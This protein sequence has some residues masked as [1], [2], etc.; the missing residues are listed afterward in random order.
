MSFDA[1]QVSAVLKGNFQPA[2]FFE[3]DAAMKRSAAGM[4]A[5]ETQIAG[6]SKRSA[7]ALGALGTVAK[8]GAAAGLVAVAAGLTASAK[9]A[10]DFEKSMR[11]VN[12]IAKVS[13]GQLKTMG[14]S[15]L[16]LAGKTAQAPKTL[17]DGLY[18]IV[19]SGFKGKDA[20]TILEKSA[21]A[22]SAG[23]TDTATASKAVVAVLN[24]Y[25]LPASQA[26]KVSDQLFGIVDRGA[27][28]FEELARQIGD[29]LPFGNQLG[30]GL[31]QLG[32]SVATLTKGGMPSAIAMTALK[33]ALVAF[34]RPSEDMSD[35]ITKSGFANGQALIK[36][37]GFQGALE[38]VSRSSGGTA[39]AMSK[40]FP[41]VQG[42]A[43]AMSLT[44]S[45]AKTAG[46]DL[47]A[48]GHVGGKSADAFAE[49][50]KSTAFQADQLKANLAVLGVEVGTAMLPALNDATS[51]VSEFVGEMNS[52]TGTGGKLVS[53]MEAITSAAGGV[54]DAVGPLADRIAPFVNTIASAKFGD[55][56][57]KLRE[58]EGAVTALGGLFKGDFGQVFR[59]LEQ[60]LGAAGDH[61]LSVFSGIARGVGIVT[62]VLSKIPGL[63][64]IFGG[65][66]DGANAAADT[67]DGVRKGLR[68]LGDEKPTIKVSANVAAAVSAIKGLDGQKIRD[69]V[70]RI[71][72]KD[73]SA[74][75]KI[76]AIR[77]LGIPLKT[78]RI[79]AAGVPKTLAEIAAVQSALGGL[80]SSKT[81]TLTTVNRIINQGS[82]VSKTPPVKLGH[83]TG[84]GP[85]GAETALVG[86]GRGGE[87]VG[88][89]G[90][91][92]WVDR[93]TVMNLAADE[94]VIPSDPAYSGRA[95]GLM[96][97]MLGV[98]GYKAGRKAKKGAAP[99][100]A[101]LPIPDAVTFGAVPEDE[102]S[103]S[104]DQARDAYQKRKDRVHNLDVDIR[105][106]RKKVGAAKGAKEKAKA[107]EKLHADERDR[108][109][110][111]DGGDGLASLVDMRKKWQ[112]LSAQSKV[113]HSTNLEIERLNTRQETDRTKM[114]TAAK[115]GDRDAWGA[116]KKDRAGILGTLRDKY[117]K[118]LDLAKPGS[119]FAAELEGKL[120]GVQ[121][122]IAD[123]T[124]EAF[125]SELS[126][127]QQAIQ[128]AAD[129]LADTGMT[130]AERAT[131]LGI[132]AQQSLAAL[133]AGT[134]DDQASASGK[135]AF[136]TGILASVQ[137]DP[138]RGGSS[139]IRDIADQVK[140]ARDNVASFAGG[141]AGNDNADLQ[142][143][144]EQQRTRAD[145]ATRS[146]QVSDRA[147]GVFQGAG[148]IGMGP[149]ITINTLHPG[150][151]RTL[152]AIA[153]AAVG[154]MS[155]QAFVTSPRTNLGL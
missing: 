67:I 79:I 98:P 123:I 137:N 31:E 88:N 129:R 95:L 49:Q 125:T 7:A 89:N 109:R 72:G 81:V 22:A 102:L 144:L 148:D 63:G 1:G 101:V 41:D 142:A 116:A 74:T 80:Q 60:I 149:S 71:L 29:V 52:G 9:Q 93:P 141:S 103:T 124:G 25:Q 155:Q 85:D 62:N 75:Q 11:N 47:R 119:S 15:V 12:T 17:A 42:L 76:Q 69:K 97:G 128:D 153:G 30:V 35:A 117:A 78:A 2:A 10:I 58:V 19:S 122:D 113:L 39:A 99:A 100:S 96:F 152:A 138:S 127:A 151:P 6:S 140:Q 139:S 40:L 86:E 94:Y 73:E 110:Y 147:L 28:T 5:A 135:L 32:G 16:A 130:D 56:T 55:F 112:A 44:G 53:D 114:A 14:K 154:G 61:I 104:K 45:K 145:V 91:W 27:I 136:L 111:R 50:M 54:A 65:L 3:F 132:E 33:G 82:K 126:P 70:A 118:A 121:G 48:M 150:D 146:A 83:A 57:G 92:A 18:D 106:D 143:Q 8:G 36:A 64:G 20:L 66:S 84:R 68:H 59:G 77:A 107:A 134:D 133:T 87:L 38:A 108:R 37:K 34:I 4:K 46:E 23:M 13:D 131:L 120:A 21:V 26:G 115:T 51:A 105:E 90:G 24:A 43:G